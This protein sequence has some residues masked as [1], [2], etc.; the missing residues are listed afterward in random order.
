CIIHEGGLAF[1]KCYSW[2]MWPSFDDKEFILVG[3]VFLLVVQESHLQLGDDGGIED[4]PIADIYLGMD[5]LGYPT[6][7]KLT[8]H[9]NKFSPQW[10]F[11]VPALSQWRRFNW[12]R[13]IFTGMVN[14][15][16]NSKSKLFANMRLNFEGEHMPF[17]AA[18]LPPAQAA[19]V[20]EDQIPLVFEHGH[21]SD[22]NIASVSGAHESDPDLFTST[23]GE[24]ETL[25][26]SFHTTP[27]RSTLVPPVGPTL[28]GTK[29]L[30]T[31]TALSSLVSE[32]V[33]K[34]STLESELT[35]HKVL[36]KEVVGKLVKKVKALELKLK[37]RSK[38]VV[39]SKSNKEEE[40]EQDVDPLVKLAKA[41]A[42]SDAH[43]DVSPGA[44]IPP[45]L[46]L[47]TGMS[48][49]V[50]S[51]VSTGP[52]AGTSNK[53][54]SPIMEED[55]PVDKR[56]FRQMEEDR[57]GEEAVKR[58][59]EEEHAN[60]ERQRAKMQRKRQQD[61]LDSAKY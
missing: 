33:Q 31:L 46:P 5:N 14:N 57:L 40:E 35:A 3:Y 52:L 49:G 2:T 32:L 22:P 19:I 30:A 48:A 28:G 24:D 39:M 53:G 54:K 6:E 60:L 13:Y 44:D 10:R 38:K 4:L 36:F 59:F 58:L 12:S 43:V 34:V 1:F 56:T 20:D 27:P 42:A 37:T 47:L 41:V 26:G 16:S 18:M 7:G 45:S 55:P 25:G 61:V 8:F 21:T 11:L 17:L 51:S 29:D 9:K 50:S 15:I 23:N